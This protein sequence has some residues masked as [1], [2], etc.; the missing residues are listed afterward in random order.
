MPTLGVDTLPN[1]YSQAHYVQDIGGRA[2]HPSVEHLV[3]LKT[4]MKALEGNDEDGIFQ[5]FDMGKFFKICKRVLLN[6]KLQCKGDDL[7]TECQ[8]WCTKL[9]IAGSAVEC[10]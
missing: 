2:G 6:G 8:N 3:V 7:L 9:Y 4:C 1:T 10:Q 5:A